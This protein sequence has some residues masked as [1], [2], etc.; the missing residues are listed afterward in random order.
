M[1]N[2]AT[3]ARKITILGGTG[4]VGSHLTKRFQ[5]NGDLVKACGREAFESELAL[6]KAIDGAE[7]LINLTGENI[8]KRWNEAYKQALCDS[9]LETAQQ[10]KQ[11]IEKC[12]VKPKAIFA[13]SAIGIYPQTACDNPLDE[14]CTEIGEGFLGELG[15]AW[16]QASLAL[17]PTPTIMRFGVVLGADGGALQKMLPPFKLGLGGPVAGGEQ[18]F[19]WV[20]VDDLTRA[21]VFLADNEPEH[22][23]YN[24]CAPTPLTNAAFGK[25]LADTLGRPFWLPLPEWQLKL[26]FGEGAQV[27]THSSAVVSKNLS[28]EGFEFEFK[29]AQSAL[30][31]LLA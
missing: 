28:A 8:G 22:E 16:E 9:R 11:A 14:S 6:V 15:A 10:I 29:A 30:Q 25:K 20:H 12:S 5:Q 7:L 26:M 18:C 17:E 23:V 31:N 3:N 19:S 24:I 4:F 2:T 27:L 1:K 13:A 21:I